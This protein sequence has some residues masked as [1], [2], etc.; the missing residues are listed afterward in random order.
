[1][2]TVSSLTIENA[3]SD[4][5]EIEGQRWKISGDIMNILVLS[6]TQRYFH[7]ITLNGRLVLWSDL[8]LTHMCLGCP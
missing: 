4:P 7:P 8:L 3:L 6:Q 5:T 2:F 1:M